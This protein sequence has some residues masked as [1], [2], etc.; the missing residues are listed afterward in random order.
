M[1]QPSN[2]T[3]E[4]II[5]DA[6]DV[7]LVEGAARDLGDPRE[8]IPASGH[9]PSWGCPEVPDGLALC[10]SCWRLITAWQLGPERCPGTDVGGG[11]TRVARSS[12]D[13]AC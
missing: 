8:E 3:L 6:P 7:T 9:W 12:S 2:L 4:P 5:L 13:F 11:P 10:V 1:N